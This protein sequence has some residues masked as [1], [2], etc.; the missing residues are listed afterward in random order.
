MGLEIVRVDRGQGEETEEAAL[1][2]GQKHK[3]ASEVPTD[4]TGHDAGPVLRRELDS[5][6][7]LL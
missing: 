2:P 3:T 1:Q 4:Y 7:C 5:W 6:L